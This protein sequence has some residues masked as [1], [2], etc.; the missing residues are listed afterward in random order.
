MIDLLLQ[1]LGLHPLLFFGVVVSE[2]GLFFLVISFMSKGVIHRYDEIQ[3]IHHGHTSRLGGLCIFIALLIGFM[4]R[5]FLHEKQ[6]IDSLFFCFSPVLLITIFEDFHIHT[7]PI[8][9][10]LAMVLASL[11]LLFTLPNSLPELSLPIIGPLL[12]E[13]YTLPIF[14]AMALIALMNGMNFIDG[15]NGLLTVTLLCS[16]FGL[17]LIA[18]LV[19]DHDFLLIILF[20]SIPLFIFLLFNYPWGKIFIG[21]VGAYWFGWVVGTL[22]IYL[23]SQHEELLAWSALLLLFYPAMEVIFSCLRKISNKKSPFHPDAN[24]L[25]LKLFFFF[26]GAFK[27][28]PLRANNFVMPFLI[29]F[30]L[31]PP[32]LAALFYQNLYMTL[33]SLGCLII[34]Y[35]W[36][37]RVVP[38]KSD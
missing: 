25:H 20:F 4:N 33:L 10:M 26:N 11:L 38:K 3:K 32:L 24:H 2:V 19:N 37:Y 22:T 31:S 13:T 15:A 21:D 23:F 29:F 9:R 18:Y 30:W 36:V 35:F 14:Y 7:K 28:Q 17:A 34:I 1:T 16:F 5:P 8:Y 12:N 6:M 27:N